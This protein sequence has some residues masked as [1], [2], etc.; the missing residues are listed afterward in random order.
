MEKEINTLH[1]GYWVRENI[2]KPRN[3][4]VTEAAKLIGISRPGVSNFLNAK[5]SAT[6][7]MAA[8][9]ERVFG[10]PAKDILNLQSLFESQVAKTEVASV[11]VRALI[12]PGFPR[13]LKAMENGRFGGVYE[14]Q[15]VYG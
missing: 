11:S 13:H 7:D 1:P 8:R 12:R 6:P 14:Q 9:L 2:L 5:V 3:L 10:V 4:T 15:A